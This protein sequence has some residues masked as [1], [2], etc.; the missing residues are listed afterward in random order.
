MKKIMLM[1]VAVVMTMFCVFSVAGCN[2]DP[3]PGPDDNDPKPSDSKIQ[4]ALRTDSITNEEYY[5]AVG[6]TDEAIVDLVIP[7]TYQGKEVR[8]IEAIPEQGGFRFNGNKNIVSITVPKTIKNIKVSALNGLT[9][10]KTVN[11]NAEDAYISMV[12]APT[13]NDR[14]FQGSKVEK[15]VIGKDVKV[16]PELFPKDDW[17]RS[18]IEELVVPD[19]LER[20]DGSVWSRKV[21]NVKVSSFD[22]WVDLY[23]AKDGRGTSAFINDKINLYVDGKLVEDLVIPESI[24]ELNAM[25]SYIESIK[26]V[27]LHKN[28]KALY[29]SYGDVY[30]LCD[31][32]NLQKIEVEEGSTHYAAKDNIL[33]NADFTEMIFVPYLIEG[34]VVVPET[35]TVIKEQQ[36]INRTKMTKIVINNTKN[37]AAQE[38]Y[39]Q[40]VFT[41]CTSLET[42]IIADGFTG[43]RDFT[44]KG[45]PNIKTVIVPASMVSVGRCVLEDS[46]NAIIYSLSTEMYSIKYSNSSHDPEGKYNTTRRAYYSETYQE[47]IS[48]KLMYWHYAEDGVTSVVW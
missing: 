30:A 12:G 2:Q 25:F 31:I 28:V 11:W 34:E 9:S 16:M 35:V 41:G 15:L 42:I 19:T 44:F 21:I 33:Y 38:G 6:V 22:K 24:T 29:T 20:F 10:L 1:I 23:T 37:E 45:C 47:A 39:S 18:Y 7:E 27:K 26:S 43:F 4:F 17:S 32:P 13:K 5:A 8:A 36:F 14:L 48:N 46:P 40:N 3:T